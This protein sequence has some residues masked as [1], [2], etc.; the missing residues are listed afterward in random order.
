MQAVESDYKRALAQV[1][2]TGAALDELVK[3]GQSDV[4]KAFEK[5]SE[6]V[7]TMGDLEKKL[8]EHAGQDERSGQ[9]ILR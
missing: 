9:R 2:V 5:Y 7:D 3:P 8:F 6:N 4:K 1:D